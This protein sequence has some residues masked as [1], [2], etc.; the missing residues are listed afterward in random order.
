VASDPGA[1][2]ALNVG[3]LDAEFESSWSAAHRPLPAVLADISSLNEPI[4]SPE[5]TGFL[6]GTYRWE[7]GGGDLAAHCRL[8]VPEQDEGCEHH[9]QHHGSGCL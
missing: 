9:R 5:W 2:T 1:H 6:G 4:N 3:Y 8:S 7:L